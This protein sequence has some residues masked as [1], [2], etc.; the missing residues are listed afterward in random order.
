MVFHTCAA[1]RA[2]ALYTRG[3]R[4]PGRYM[5]RQAVLDRRRA[6]KGAPDEL[7]DY[8]DRDRATCAWKSLHVLGAQAARASLQKR[9]GTR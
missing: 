2:R 5:L 7:V 3:R 1:M 6:D 9:G 8:A 4:L